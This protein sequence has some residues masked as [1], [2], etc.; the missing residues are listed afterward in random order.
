M[1][2]CDGSECVLWTLVSVFVFFFSLCLCFYMVLIY[3]LLHLEACDG[4]K[5]VL[6][7]SVSVFFFLSLFVFLLGANLCFVTSTACKLHTTRYQGGRY[8]STMTE[9][10]PNMSSW[11]FV[12]PFLC[13]SMLIW[14]LFYLQFLIYTLCNREVDGWLRR[15]ERAQTM[16]LYGKYFFLYVFTSITTTREGPKMCLGLGDFFFFKK[17][18]LSFVICNSVFY[19]IYSS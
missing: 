2:A 3:V 12:Y 13:S 6:W 16:S 5:C 8:M 9:K 19:S 17:K 10:S 4:S 7:T 18:N 1:E 14:N 11:D 15:K